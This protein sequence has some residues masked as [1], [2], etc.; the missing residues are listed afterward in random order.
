MQQSGCPVLRGLYACGVCSAAVLSFW[1]R[2]CLRN[3]LRGTYTGLFHG[4]YRPRR[5]S[6][7]AFHVFHVHTA[8]S[9][10][11]CA[12]SSAPIHGASVC[13]GRHSPRPSRGAPNEA[14]SHGASDCSGSL[15]SSGGASRPGIARQTASLRDIASAEQHSVRPAGVSRLFGP[16]MS[17]P[18]PFRCP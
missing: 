14:A 5:T 6:G 3:M 9:R 7:R 10:R 13:S 8:P 18:T 15:R 1:L 12:E 11:I 16:R 2:W 4:V 17:R